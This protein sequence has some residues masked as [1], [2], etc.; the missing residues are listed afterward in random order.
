MTATPASASAGGPA[1]CQVEGGS[2]GDD[3]SEGQNATCTLTLLP[4]AYSVSVPSSIETPDSEVDI[5][6]AYPSGADPQSVALTPGQDA[7]VN[8]ASAY[9]PT[10]TINLA[11]PLE[12]AAAQ[13]DCPPSTCSS[14][15]PLYDD[16]AVDGT[17]ATVTPTGSTAGAPQT[18][19]LD[20]GYPG[21]NVSYG[22]DATCNVNVA[23]GTYTVSLPSTIETPYSEV[24]IPVAYVT[25][26]N[27]QSVTVGSGQDTDVNFTSAYEPTVTVNLAGPLEPNCSSPECSSEGT[28]YDNDAVDGATATI[29][30]S[31]GTSGAQQTCQLE[32]GYPGDNVN[33]GQ[34]ATCTVGVTPGTYSVSL[35]STIDTTYSEVGIPLAYVTAQDPQTVTIASGGNANVNFASAYEPTISVTL[36]GPAEPSCGASSCSSTATVYDDD[37]VNGTTMTVTPTGSTSG[38]PVSC[39]AE[40]GEPGGIAGNREEASCDVGVTPGTYKVSVPSPIA[41]EPDYGW[42]YIDV[43]SSNPDQVTVAAGG[44]ATADF[45]TSYETMGNVGTGATSAR[46]KD[47]LV[48]ATGIGGTGTVTVGEYHSDPERPGDLQFVQPQRRLL[49]RSRF[50]E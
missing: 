43:T 50:P 7:V 10:L 5:P 26:E 46:T 6:L 12:P 9:Q 27:P 34:D 41:P 28:V 31:G 35:P 33:Y 39:Q 19:Q 29:T 16:D 38:S 14:E 23:P 44:D 24:S 15:G 42:G 36:A 1:S 37:A 49:R 25:G 18:C 40:G 3:V 22:Q 8:F 20:G 2:P 17:T 30:P 4:G 21:D 11:G 48:T 13:A 32:G 47:G 45:N